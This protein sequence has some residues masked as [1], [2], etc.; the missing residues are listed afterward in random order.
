MQTKELREKSINELKEHKQDLAKQRCKLGLSLTSDE[1]IKNHQF[2]TLRREI[3]RVNTI[4]A[5]KKVNED[6]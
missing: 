1:K 5:E 3:A 4:I 2:K 6:A